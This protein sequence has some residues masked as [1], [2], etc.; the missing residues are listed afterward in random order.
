MLTNQNGLAACS[1]I[2]LVDHALSIPDHDVNQLRAQLEQYPSVAER[3]ATMFGLH[4]SDRPTEIENLHDEIL[5]RFWKY[6]GCYHLSGGNNSQSNWFVMDE[7]G[8]S[9]A[10]SG[11][12]N[13]VCVPFLFINTPSPASQP[14]IVPFSIVW[15]SQNIAHED[16]VERDF[17]SWITTPVER[18]AH[19]CDWIDGVDEELLGQLKTGSVYHSD[20]LADITKRGG[21]DGQ[22]FVAREF[23]SLESYITTRPSPLP[24]LTGSEW[25]I[26]TADDDPLRFHDAIGGLSLPSFTIV[27]DK[28]LADIL[29]LSDPLKVDETSEFWCADSKIN[30]EKPRYVN[31]FPYEGVLCMKNI[32][33]REIARCLGLPKWWLPCY[34]LETHLTVFVG[35]YLNRQETT[36]SN[37]ENKE[38]NVWIAKPSNGTRSSG[39]VVSDSL[40]RVIRA[41]EV[42]KARIAQKYIEKPLLYQGKYKLDMRFVILVRSFQPGYEEVYIY[43]EF[44]CRVASKPHLIESPNLNCDG[45]VAINKSLLEDPE[46]HLTAG[47][48]HSG[49]DERKLPSC[50]DVIDD[51]LKTYPQLKWEEIYGEICHLIR[52]LLLGLSKG[53]GGNMHS[54]QARAIYGLDIMLQSITNTAGD[55]IAAQPKLLEVSFTPANNAVNPIYAKQ[56]PT[57]VNDVISCLF[58]G[59][60]S[61][62]TR[63][64]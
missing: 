3:L 20:A 36:V 50:D 4:T 51:L 42:N 21:V 41:L 59:S 56:Y 15:P 22:C 7:L 13:V 54:K 34:D 40:I 10:H 55:V 39:H 37:V 19:L 9:I 18:I 5:L 6:A 11:E 43:N 32:M 24:P 16:F 2:F 14:Q 61:N 30:N 48:L 12:P 58:L 1:E 49:N 29:W 28:D 25:K 33:T 17:C 31:Q 23:P 45:P 46:S 8:S 26:Y 44:W 60:Q 35:D 47:Y 53:Q 38:Y 57:Y 27:K 64:L 62:V 63:I 52:E